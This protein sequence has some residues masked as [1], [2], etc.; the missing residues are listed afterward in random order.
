MPES[1][2]NIIDDIK[3]VLDITSRVDERAKIIADSQQK[4]N[5]RLDHLIDEHNN[6]ASRVYVLESKGGRKIIDEIEDKTNRLKSRI[7]LL[8]SAGSPWHQRIVESINNIKSRL[9]KLEDHKD[10]VNYKLKTFFGYVFQGTFV[11][12]VCY[13]LY[14]MGLNPP[15]MP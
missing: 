3:L 12:L 5:A 15:P 1:H 4:I 6:L 14:R 13:I 10:G 9:N 11:I 8:E 7:E 2:N